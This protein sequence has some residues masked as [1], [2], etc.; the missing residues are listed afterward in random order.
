LI[1]ASLKNTGNY[2][3]E[4]KFS[5]TK[6]CDNINK[7]MDHFKLSKRMFLRRVSGENEDITEEE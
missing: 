3:A 5:L 6:F 7:Y 2:N 1:K 4:M